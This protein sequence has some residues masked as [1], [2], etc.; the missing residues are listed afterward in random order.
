MASKGVIINRL[1]QPLGS[2]YLSATDHTGVNC[3]GFV[4][5]DDTIITLLEG[6]DSS[7]AAT[8]VDYKASMNL[9]GVTL[10]RG[11]FITSPTG[12]AFQN[13]NIS[14]GAVL[15][16]NSLFQG[17]KPSGIVPLLL[18]EYP[19][20]AAAYSLRK[21]RTE[22]TGDAIEVR[23]SVGTPAN[24]NIGFDSNGELDTDAL[25]SFVGSNDG[26]V[27]TWYDQSGEGIDLTQVSASGQG[28]IVDSGVINTKGNKPCVVLDG[29]ANTYRWG[30]PILSLTSIF[31][32]GS[33]NNVDETIL[34]L[35]ASMGAIGT[36]RFLQNKLGF[37]TNITNIKDYTLG[38]LF[39]VS[40]LTSPDPDEGFIN[41]III[42]QSGGNLRAN[43]GSA[44]W[45][46]RV[47]DFNTDG[48]IQELVMYVSDQSTDREAIE[49]NINNYYTI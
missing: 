23:R 3:T 48:T 32:V 15:A 30:S 7:V 44:H 34:N 14:E 43:S 47:G 28:K 33:I 25:L 13:I 39:V 22:Y 21:L 27:V 11:A 37:R 2:K 49:T 26:F 41:S 16:Y 31:T 8:D 1:S 17:E 20:A 35:T 40:L 12:E 4:A 36:D 6:G 38:D 45:G 10:K 24:Q 29:V 5:Q 19:N 18:D 9:D 42:N 46:S